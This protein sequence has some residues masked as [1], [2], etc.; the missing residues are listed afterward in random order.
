[1]HPP[2]EHQLDTYLESVADRVQRLRQR[3]LFA[4]AERQH[5][6]AE[7]QDM[8]GTLAM[9]RGLLRRSEQARANQQGLAA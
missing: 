9:C 4:H 5:A 7:I 6:L 2:M 1:M 3:N 8:L